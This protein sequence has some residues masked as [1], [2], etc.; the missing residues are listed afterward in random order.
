MESINRKIGACV[1][2]N[3]YDEQYSCIS[4][5][6]NADVISGLKD[7]IFWDIDSAIDDSICNIITNELVFESVNNLIKSIYKK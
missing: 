6:I 3:I 5:N 2:V 1:A 4:K 7:D